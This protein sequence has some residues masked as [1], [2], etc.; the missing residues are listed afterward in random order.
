MNKLTSAD[1][2]RSPSSRIPHSQ[3]GHNNYD[4]NHLR[5]QAIKSITRDRILHQAS[6]SEPDYSFQDWEYMF[7]L[8]DVLEPVSESVSSRPGSPGNAVE[9]TDTQ[10]RR[11]EAEQVK[12]RQSGM[13]AWQDGNKVPDWLHG[14][15][16]LNVTESVT[17]WMLLALIEK[18]E[19]ELADLRRKEGNTFKE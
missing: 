8:M 4:K 18:L 11:G 19:I 12:E 3:L 14:K 1:T 13:D 6:S 5:I 16:P 15:N 2:Y 17:E 10:E 9:K 7:W